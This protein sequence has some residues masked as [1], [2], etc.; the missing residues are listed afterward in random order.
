[1]VE[2]ES[3]VPLIILVGDLVNSKI[4]S[5]CFLNVRLFFFFFLQSN[6]THRRSGTVPENF[7]P[8]MM[9][10]FKDHYFVYL[11]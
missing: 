11:V 7:K 2:R 3:G 8:C 9:L 6:A 1:M 10:F 4:I 5:N